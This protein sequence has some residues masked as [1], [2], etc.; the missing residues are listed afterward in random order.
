MVYKAIDTTAETRVDVL[1][2]AHRPLLAYAS[3]AHGIDS[4]NRFLSTMPYKR[5][6]DDIDLVRPT[7]YRVNPNRK[8]KEPPPQ[9]WPLPA[10]NPLHIL[11]IT[12]P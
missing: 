4:S 8:V 9:P 12:E 5:T 1:V 6:S 7:Q 3:A 11:L 10:F 2:F